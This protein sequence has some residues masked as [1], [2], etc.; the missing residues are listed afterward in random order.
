MRALPSLVGT[1][2][3]SHHGRRTLR[4]L[5]RSSGAESSWA[6]EEPAC[7]DGGRVHRAGLII[8]L[9][10]TLLVHALFD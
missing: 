7:H 9:N 1:A 4:G 3:V 5:L 6:V 2:P 10:V 8:G